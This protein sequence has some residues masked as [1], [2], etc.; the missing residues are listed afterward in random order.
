VIERVVVVGAGLA[1]LRA[2]EGLRSRG[3]EGEIVLVG[4]EEHLP[5]D[6]P[7]LSKQFLAG[8]WDLDQV[9]LRPAASFAELHL[10][11]RTGAASRAVAL[12][13]GRQM[14]ALSSGDELAYDACV[15]ATGARARTLASMSGLPGT[16]V[17]RT[18]DDAVGLRTQLRE[19]AGGRVA[20]I[21]GGFVGLEVAATARSLSCAVTVIE[22]LER[23][24]PRVLGSELAAICRSMHEAHG[25][26]VRTGTALNGVSVR[27][28]PGS[29]ELVLELSDGSHTTA[30]I[31]VVGIGS[32]LNSEWLDGSGLVLSERGV[33]TDAA[34]RAAPNV[35][36]AGDLAAW[37][38]HLTGSVLRL[39]HRT[40]AAEQGDHV[41]AVI[42]G[43]VVPF[44]TVPYVWSDQYDTKIQIL[45]SPAGTDRWTILD[46]D[47]EQGRVVA[48]AE[49]AGTI[50]GIV[51]FNMARAVMRLRPLLTEITRLEDAEALLR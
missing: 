6:R 7:P 5:Y 36:V 47:P 50:S 26:V 17:L 29:T 30:D 4:D 41:A 33:M 35:L 9:L 23:V 20:V 43:G 2:C 10:D 16:H 3:F 22:P 48:V 32:M 34:L 27:G 38:H 21:G 31:V 24:L 19:R 8:T 45:G 11:R 40:N 28:E 44:I 37:P 12:D 13:V 49:R 51:G 14:V 25:V 1:G 15:L 46:G 42:V 39:E 18:L